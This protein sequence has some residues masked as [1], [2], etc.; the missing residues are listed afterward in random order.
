MKRLLHKLIAKLYRQLKGSHYFLLYQSFRRKYNLADDFKFNGESIS[1]YGD[2]EII[3]GSNSY[4]GSLSTIRSDKNCIVK[5]GRN[6]SISHNVRMYTS[7]NL[8]DQNFDTNAIK[9]KKHDN[10]IIGN[11]VWIGANVFINP[12]VTIGDNVV[13][14]ANSVVTKD[15]ESNLIIGGVPAK[16]IKEKNV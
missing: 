7:S 13:I 15:F 12:G 16:Q 11:G 14:G 3:I 6:C 8:A 4:I 2:G 1:F 10:I 5:I 9:L